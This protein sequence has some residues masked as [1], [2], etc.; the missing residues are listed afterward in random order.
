[1]KTP[2]LP[3]ALTVK[4]VISILFVNSGASNTVVSIS[5]PS[6]AMLRPNFLFR[7]IS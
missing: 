3:F 1:V 5:P 2:V 6:P 4:S 7:I